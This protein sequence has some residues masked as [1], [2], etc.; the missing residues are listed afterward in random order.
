MMLLMDKLIPCLKSQKMKMQ[1]SLSSSVLFSL[2]VLSSV[3]CSCKFQDRE[4][5]PVQSRF[6]SAT[7]LK[8]LAAGF[9]SPPDNTRAWVYWYVMDGNLNHEGITADLEAMKRAGIGGA[10]LLEIDQ[11]VPRGK[12]LMMS[13]AWIDHFKFIHEEASR[14]GI[15]I[16]LNSGPGWT[17]TGGP[18]IKS[19]D[20][21]QFIIADTLSI[22]GGREVKVQ[23]P[24][25]K[26]LEPYFSYVYK[27]TP[28]MDS[29]RKSYYTDAYTL[30]YPKPK[31][32]LSVI[33]NFAN[34]AMYTPDGL[35]RFHT[36]FHRPEQ[37]WMWTS[38]L[39]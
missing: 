7:D 9:I 2:L 21:M 35:L 31:N 1:H 5:L 34:K 30:A 13:Q 3:L 26:P 12:T 20:A 15:E 23:L 29:T 8:S 32:A 22:T 37:L 14:L 33:P 11:N 39:I 38:A 10:I 16:T 36:L 19:S 4:N 6:T 28:G 24:Q 17:G 27:I 18:W 25:A